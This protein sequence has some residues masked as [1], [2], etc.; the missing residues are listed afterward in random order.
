M[1]QLNDPGRDPLELER[2][3]LG[4][5]PDQDAER[6]D[7]MSIS[8]DDVAGR[9]RV[10]ENDLVDAYVRGTLS[11]EKLERFESFYLSSER[12]R[13]KV[14]FAR[15][16]L[17]A[18][19]RKADP[20]DTDT[21][22]RSV[23]G[24]AAERD[25]A[26]LGGAPSYASIATSPAKTAWRLCAAAALLLVVCGAL[27]YQD[28]RLRSG[29]NEAQR[30]S[31][32]LSDRARDLEQ[33][34]VSQRAAGT[35]DVKEVESP[36]ASRT[37]PAVASVL[38]PQ[39]RGVGPIVILAVPQEVGQVALELRLESNDFPRYQ[40]ALRDPG[41]NHIVWRSDKITARSADNVPTVSLTVPASALK[42]QHYSIELDG[43]PAAGGTEVAGSYTFQVVRR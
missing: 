22:S 34:L 19:D 5:L 8:D 2:Y 31:A 9:L 33:Q 39:M 16:F 24:P 28:V 12:R 30:V 14:R 29:L 3:L 15:T 36:R 32:L 38:L 7:E 37:L 1:S 26:L 27:L 43:L 35:R 18:V 10:V 20:A 6:L 25:G 4:L 40:A 21:G 23:R 41:T 42:A 17:R 13:Q 11:G